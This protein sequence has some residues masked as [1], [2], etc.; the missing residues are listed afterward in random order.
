MTVQK[1]LS[2]RPVQVWFVLVAVTAISVVLAERGDD[3]HAGADIA[4]NPGLVF[5]LGVLLIAAIKARLVMTH[6]MEVGTAPRALR[7]ACDLW[8]AASM[9]AVISLFPLGLW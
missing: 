5:N 6:F 4:D 1:A 9:V 3:A 2:Q 8:L 7:Y